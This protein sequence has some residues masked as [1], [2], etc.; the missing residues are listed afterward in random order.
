MPFTS[1][2]QF[3][4][5]NICQN[6]PPEPKKWRLR[7]KRSP[8]DSC[9]SAGGRG[10][11]TLNGQPCCPIPARK[12]CRLR[13]KQ[14]QSR[15]EQAPCFVHAFSNG[16]ARGPWP[17]HTS[18]KLNSGDSGAHPKHR[19][20]CGDLSAAS[21]RGAA[22][23]ARGKQSWTLGPTRPLNPLLLRSAGGQPSGNAARVPSVSARVP[24][25]RRRGADPLRLTCRPLSSL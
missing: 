4:R 23:Q 2:S 18:K 25:M 1:R 15:I 3:S 14:V 11:T 22:V 13:R 16:R 21:C 12:Q 9:H 20:I 8:P 24:P 19:R 10:R 17:L 7:S 5:V 6:M